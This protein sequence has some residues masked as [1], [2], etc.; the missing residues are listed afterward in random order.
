LVR[1]L[2]RKG[3]AGVVAEVRHAVEAFIIFRRPYSRRGIAP[4]EI[5]NLAVARHLRRR[6]IGRKLV[7]SIDNRAGIV[8]VVGEQNL[9][10]Q[11]FFRALGFCATG[12]IPR[13]FEHGQDGYRFV[14]EVK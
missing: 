14:Y 3:N 1:V 8:A 10:A 13:H 9:E 7:Q 4:M 11:L 12:I 5:L 2:G 6:G